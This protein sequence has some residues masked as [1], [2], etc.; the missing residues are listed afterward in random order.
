VAGSAKSSAVS[1][2][3]IDSPGATRRGLTRRNG[4]A[5]EVGVEPGELEKP[6]SSS[7]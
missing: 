1:S 6:I 4:V 3:R 2:S 7:K 5:H